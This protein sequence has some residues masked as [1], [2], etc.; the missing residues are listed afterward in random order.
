MAA[1]LSEKYLE[2]NN[3]QSIGILLD[4]GKNILKEIG[5]NRA[6]D[7]ALLLMS[8]LLNKS[9]SEIFL[10]RTEA[11][12]PEKSKKYIRC[13]KKEKKVCPYSILPDIRISWG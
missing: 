3:I 7:E 11:I 2:D 9:K 4:I 10:N 12:P 13:L 5:N 1:S 8:Y 6:E